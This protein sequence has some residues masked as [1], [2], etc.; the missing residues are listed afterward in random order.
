M[1]C[2]NQL[3]EIKNLLFDIE[4]PRFERVKD[5]QSAIDAML[6][7]DMKP[8]LKKLAEDI[9]KKGLN[10]GE[11]LYVAKEN[12]K[13]IVLE[14]NRRLTAIKLIADPQLIKND[15]KSK[16]FFQNLNN[17]YVNKLSL[18]L[19]CVVFNNKKDAWPWIKKKHTGENKGVGLVPWDTEQQER[20]QSQISGSQSKLI[21]V[22]DFIQKHNIRYSGKRSTIIEKLLNTPYVRKQIGIDFKK[23]ELIL[24]VQNEK[25]IVRNFKKVIE[26]ID[27]SNFSP[28]NTIDSAEKRKIWIDEVLGDQL[29][30]KTSKAEKKRNNGKIKKQ[31]STNNKDKKT[32]IP[33]DFILNIPQ[34][35]INLIYEELKSLNIK[36]Y[37]NAVAVLFRVFLEL[38][39]DHF[40]DKN[41]EKI[42]LKSEKSKR[43]PTLK[44]KLEGIV[45]YMEKEKIL[46]THEL[47]PIRTSISDKDSLFSIDT[48]NSYVHNRDHNPIT[49]YLEKT[50][51]NYSKFIPKLWE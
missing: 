9:A 42:E 46:T 44:D 39:L 19:N 31:T 13:Y 43:P 51:S 29:P 24:N 34:E 8:K 47:K 37:N 38:S 6:R 7:K 30:K 25:S 1:N 23:G 48:F 35:R 16:K 22:L 14:G 2:K 12:K 45:K 3:I 21:Q 41:K 10:P 15:E 4:N 18:K 20:F 36:K 33:S 17:K 40:I 49:E 27:A 50:W 32:L 26:K 11:P 28:R 5:Q